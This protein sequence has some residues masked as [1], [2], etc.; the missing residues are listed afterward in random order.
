MTEISVSS[1][2]AGTQSIDDNT[3]GAFGLISPV[4]LFNTIVQLD[5]T[6]KLPA[7]NGENVKNILVT[8]SVN[9]LATA[10]GSI[11][12]LMVAPYA[13]TVNRVILLPGTTQQRAMSSFPLHPG[14]S[15]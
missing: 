4:A 3:A 11:V 1:P 7:V 9:M 10:G 8:Q 2:M 12:P 6:G 14:T 15:G 13:L 5:G